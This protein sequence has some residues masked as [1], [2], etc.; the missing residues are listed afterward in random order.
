MPIYLSFSSRLTSMLCVILS[1]AG[2]AGGTVAAF[3]D[4]DLGAAFGLDCLSGRL[5][6]VTFLGGYISE[7]LNSRYH[8]VFKMGKYSV[9]YFDGLRM[10]SLCEQNGVFCKR[11]STRS[12]T[13]IV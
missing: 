6:L 5:S 3:S 7:T 10:R 13:L 2:G 4:R 12:S 1:G 8:G 11:E 9:E